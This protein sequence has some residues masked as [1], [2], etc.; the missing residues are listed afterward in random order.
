LETL[1]SHLSHSHIF[2]HNL[3]FEF[4]I[5]IL[6][7]IAFNT[8]SHQHKSLYL[9]NFL[10]LIPI[11]SH[12]HHFIFSAYFFFYIFTATFFLLFNIVLHILMNYVLLIFLC[13]KIWQNRKILLTIFMFFFSEWK[14]ELS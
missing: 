1:K 3:K 14:L 13:F 2:P 5:E 11:F 7:F 12:I 10:I 9:S 6:K 4:W 8:F